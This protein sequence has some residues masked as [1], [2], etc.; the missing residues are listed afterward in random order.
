MGPAYPARLIEY[1]AT[2]WRPEVA[3]RNAESLRRAVACLR[4]LVANLREQREA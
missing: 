1:A 3:A 4:R 2:A